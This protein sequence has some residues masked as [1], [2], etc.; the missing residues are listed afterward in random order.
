MWLHCNTA[1][2]EHVTTPGCNEIVPEVPVTGHSLLSITDVNHA[3]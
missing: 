1:E 2:Y 3:I